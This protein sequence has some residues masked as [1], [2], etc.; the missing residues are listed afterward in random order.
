MGLMNIKKTML[1]AEY[2]L[3]EAYA[4]YPEKHSVW[5]KLSVPTGTM[6]LEAELQTPKIR[7]TIQSSL[8]KKILLEFRR[9][10]T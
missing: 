1:Q 2:V 9:V 3:E 5:D 7:R 4:S 10:I 8:E 6:T